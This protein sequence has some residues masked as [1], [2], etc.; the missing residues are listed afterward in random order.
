VQR[1]H[2]KAIWMM[3][4]Q[5]IYPVMTITYAD[6]HYTRN[7][8][9]GEWPQMSANDRIDRLEQVIA[10]LQARRNEIITVLMWEICKSAVDAAAEFDRTMLFIEATIAAYRKL[11]REEG[12]WNTISGIFAR[13]RRAAIGT[14]C[15]VRTVSPSKSAAV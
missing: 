3:T 12:G 15:T 9:F 4:A 11:D 5:L 13:V 10:G 8:G 7:H 6:L 1:R 2:G 14:Y